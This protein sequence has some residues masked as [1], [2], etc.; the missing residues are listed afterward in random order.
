MTE[1][2]VLRLLLPCP[3]RTAERAWGDYYFGHSLGE[4]LERLGWQVRY[5]YRHRSV[6][7]RLRSLWERLR[8][9]REIEI[10][11]R[12]KRAW[13][14]LPGKCAVMWLISQSSSVRPA[15][16]RRYAHVFVASPS[17]LRRIRSACHAS[18]LPQCTDAGR[19]GPRTEPGSGRPIFVGNRRDGMPRDIVRA[20]IDS[21]F[22]VGVWGRGWDD[23]P[24]GHYAGL[25]I[26]NRD[27]GAH[28]RAAGAV[29]NDHAE[30]MRRDGFVS[31]RVY[32]VLACAT[33]LV[34]EDMDGLPQEAASRLFLYRSV[35]DVADTI[36]DALASEAG[37]E[38]ERVALARQILELHTFDQRAEAI[39][40]IIENIV[41][42]Q[43]RRQIAAPESPR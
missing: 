8:H 4:A 12:G 11:L 35:D 9:P 5:S 14:P 26:E 7:A 20:A 6:A 15:E 40:E 2:P 42:M 37:R 31:N 39:V 25:H 28:Y 19:F 18:L 36:R 29:L 1:R 34:T 33:P 38:A 30:D 22:D 17:F 16:L 13:V 21:G 23:L 10:V 32:D 43:A 3:P 27:L 41:N 24:E